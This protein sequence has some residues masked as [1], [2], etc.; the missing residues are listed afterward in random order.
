MN[1]APA[2]DSPAGL[3]NIKR[4]VVLMFENRSFDHL[5]GAFPGANGLFKNGHINQDCY[6]LPDP[7]NP[8]S[9][10]NKPFYPAP[11]NPSIPQAHDFTHDFGDGMMPDLFGPIFTVSG[12]PPDPANRGAV[13]TSGYADGKVVGA[14]STPPPQTYPANNSGFVTTYNSCVQQGQSAMTYFEY[15]SLKVLHKLAGEFVLCDNW[16]CDMP[17]HTL[18]NRAFIHCGTTNQVGIDDTD[19]GMVE[20]QS[21]FD[22]IDVYGPLPGTNWKMYAPVDVLN[23]LGQLDTRFLNKALHGYKGCPITEFVTDCANDNLPFYSFIMCWLPRSDA[24]TDTSMHPNALVQP[25]ENLL[26]AVY[27]TLRN[28]PCWDDTLLVVTFDENGG[29]YDHVFPPNT[30]PPDPHAPTET[31]SVVGCCGNKWTLD[32]SFDFSLLGF[33]VPAL[34]IS[35][36]LSKGID[37]N[38]YQNTSVLRFLTDRFNVVHGTKSEYLTQRDANAPRLDSAFSQFGQGIMRQDCPGWIEPYTILPSVD[39]HTNSNDIPYREGQLTA[40]N[41]PP[42]M[43]EAPPVPYIL[44]L[45]NMYVRPLPGHP[46][47]GKEITQNFATNADVIKYT[48]ER[49]Q[50]AGVLPTV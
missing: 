5:F 23:N 1:Q 43:D 29:I 44:E 34:L 39:P 11:I 33:R 7:L 31:Q 46:D 22:R 10:N 49:V 32:S 6:N 14:T 37:S 47:S 30:T 38:Q 13:Y 45:L 3:A 18:P 20:A 17:G 36:W 28:S 16:H 12:N 35:P 25:G 24:W 2:N 26:A 4:V 21:I 50:A 48:N 40:W 8:P 41:P 9:E 15:G 19:G 27:N 42:K